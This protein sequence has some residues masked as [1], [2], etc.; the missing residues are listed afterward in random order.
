[1]KT[2]HIMADGTIRDNLD[3]VVIPEEM[4]AVVRK[5]FLEQ[6]LENKK[7]REEKNETIINN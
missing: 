1:M 6:A 4:I 2:M 5:V 7:R 3:G